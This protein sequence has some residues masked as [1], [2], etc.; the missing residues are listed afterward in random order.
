M[1]GSCH[2]LAPIGGDCLDSA[3]LSEMQEAASSNLQQ[4]GQL[5]RAGRTRARKCVL[6]TSPLQFQTTFD[7]IGLT[8]KKDAWSRSV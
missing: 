1:A 7:F 5:N 3:N 2:F 8:E 6:Q 4:I